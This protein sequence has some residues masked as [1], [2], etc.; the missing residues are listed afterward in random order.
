VVNRF[1]FMAQN[2]RLV[3]EG[4]KPGAPSPPSGRASTRAST[5]SARRFGSRASRHEGPRSRHVRLGDQPPG[6]GGGREGR[7]ARRFAGRP[8]ARRR[9]LPACTSRDPG[10]E[11]GTIERGLRRA[12]PAA[13]ARS[14]RRG[15]DRHLDPDL[16]SNPEASVPESG[17]AEPAQATAEAPGSGRGPA[18]SP[19]AEE[20]G[21]QDA[22]HE[23]SD[24][25]GVRDAPRLRG[26]AFRSEAAR[27]L[28][29]DPQPASPKTQR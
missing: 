6:R 17:P 28:D 9:A 22:R 7:G 29:Q 20:S 2:N 8:V 1:R 4:K 19:G 14:T 12:G 25:R 26:P 15:A 3:A 10:R 27:E 23:S 18:P 16:C 11:R 21:Q 5:T 13:P 24:V